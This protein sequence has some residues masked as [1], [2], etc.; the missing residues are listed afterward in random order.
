MRAEVQRAFAESIVVIWRVLTG[1]SVFA[2]GVA[3]VMRGLPL[4]TQVDRRWAL[5]G[6]KDKDRDCEREVGGGTTD[7]GE[8]LEV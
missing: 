4:H 1:L 6:G 7:V 2:F 8:K 3:F 5:E